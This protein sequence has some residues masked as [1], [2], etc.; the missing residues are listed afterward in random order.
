MDLWDVDILRVAPF[1]ANPRY[2]RERTV[3]MVGRLYAMHWPFQQPATARGVRRSVLHDRL[4]ARGACFGAVMG[5]ER[6]NWYARPGM[7]PVYRYSWGRQNW[8]P[9]WKAEHDAEWARQSQNTLDE[10]ALAVHRRGGA[11]AA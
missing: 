9:W 2:L 1:E 10:L 7:E 6:A 4:A 3:E 8:F 11:L 5:W